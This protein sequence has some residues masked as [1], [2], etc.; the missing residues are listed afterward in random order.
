MQ[1]PLHESLP[2]KEQ[3]LAPDHSYVTVQ[4]VTAEHYWVLP[5]YHS[6]L[7]PR[8]LWGEYAVGGAS[9]WKGQELPEVECRTFAPF[10]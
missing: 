8:L 4:R 6:L 7:L 2:Y 10:L 9:W 1:F 5:V 3:F